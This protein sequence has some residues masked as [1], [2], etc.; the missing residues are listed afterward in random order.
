MTHDIQ[1]SEYIANFNIKK[2]WILNPWWERAGKTNL[3]KFRP[4]LW[5][6]SVHV[7]DVATF[8]IY[9]LFRTTEYFL[10]IRLKVGRMLWK[11]RPLEIF[12]VTTAGT[13]WQNR[14]SE[15]W[16][17]WILRKPFWSRK[18]GN[19]AHYTD[20]HAARLL[21][22]LHVWISFHIIIQTSVKYLLCVGRNV[23]DTWV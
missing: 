9:I 2:L 4:L 8:R 12:A 22:N 14:L 15:I 5:A 1:F 6:C 17:D 13:Q 18:Y 19:Q 20:K 21:I 16:T 3:L 10:R 11:S 23:E 7:P